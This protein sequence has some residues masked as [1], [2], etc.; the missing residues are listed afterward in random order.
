MSN[1]D[2]A[3]WQE[4]FYKLVNITVNVSFFFQNEN[5]GLEDGHNTKYLFFVS[6]GFD[7]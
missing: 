2:K 3:D 5:V 4:Y 7:Y 1:F 6:P